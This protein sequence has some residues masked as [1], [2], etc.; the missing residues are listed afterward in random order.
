MWSDLDSTGSFTVVID[1]DFDGLAGK[2]ITT[3]EQT[4]MMIP[5]TLPANASIEVVMEADGKE[6]TLSCVIAANIWKPGFTTTYKVSSSSITGESFLTV[7]PPVAFDYKGGTNSYN[8]AS[9]KLRNDGTTVPAKWSVTG[10]S[11][12]GGVTWSNNSPG[13]LILT[14]SGD[15]GEVATDY[16]ATV[17]AQTTKCHN[18][19][20]SNATPV[21]G[22]YDLSTNGGT[23]PMNTANCYV[24]N[25]PGRYSLP[26]VY[27]NAVKNGVANPDAYITKTPSG[28]SYILYEFINHLG[29]KITDPY[30]YNNKDCQAASAGLVW[31]DASQLVTNIALANGGH[32]I[33]F[34]VSQAHITQGNAVIAVYDSNNKIIWS[35]HIWVTDYH[36]GDDLKLVTNKQGKQ[37]NLM[38]INLGW[39]Y[40][41]KE[42]DSYPA[43]SVQVRIAQNGGKTERIMTVRQNSY[44]TESGLMGNQPYYQCGRKDPMLPNNGLE[45]QQNKVWYDSNGLASNAV[46]ID[47]EPRTTNEGIVFCIQNPFVYYGSYLIG[48]TECSLNNDYANLWNINPMANPNDEPTSGEIHKTIYDPSPVGYSLPA[49][50]AFNGFSQSNVSGRSQYGFSFTINAQT[51]ETIFFPIIG[52]RRCGGYYLG[53]KDARDSTGALVGVSSYSLYYTGTLDNYGSR[54]NYRTATYFM[55]NLVSGSIRTY[56]GGDKASG[57]AIRCMQERD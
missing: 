43:R 50:A 38:P 46:K 15:G 39:C 20:L 33:E 48:G 7:T 42:A 27:G 12:D 19:L 29:N 14:T 9:Y 52:E 55:S 17:T 24:I 25:A 13:W 51:K 34:E 18:D 40:T 1:K 26:L 2:E 10:Y 23:S 4:L 49:R 22:T 57:G 37:F 35:W 53:S 56:E 36:L 41:S 16:N 31:Q 6:Q 44:T 45:N 54:V 32:N 47:Y 11:T 5:Q 8:I 3:T 30:I 28:L 21:A